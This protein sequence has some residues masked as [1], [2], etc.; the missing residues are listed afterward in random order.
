MATGLVWDERFMWHENDPTA[1]FL[2]PAGG[3]VQPGQHVEN[4]ETK[5][6]IKN[7]LDASGLTRDLVPIDAR[8]ATDE[9]ILSVHERGFLDSLKAQDASGGSAGPFSLFAAGGF[10]IIRLA[11]GGTLEALDAIMAGRIRNA[12]A[13]V[14]PCGHHATPDAGMGFA[15]LNNGAMAAERAMAQYGV[16]RVAIVD[17]DVHHGNGTQAI[18]WR[19]PRVLTISIHQEACF[20]P[21]GGWTDEVGEGPGEGYNINIALP[22][23]SGEGA[24]EAAMEEV[25]LPALRKFEPGLIIVPSGFDAGGFDP[26][27]RQML[28]SGAFRSMA[29]KVIDL[30]EAL[31]HGRVLAV[32]EGGYNSHTVPFMALAVIEELA[33][34]R[35]PV[36]D[37]FLPMLANAYGQAIR[38]HQQEAVDRARAVFERYSPHW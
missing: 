32:H 4:P 24:Y 35:S 29:R 1:A 2:M 6:R 20:P 5:R 21:E 28:S 33:G 38:P 31:G 34:V 3:Y 23:G 37:P 9:E 16:D 14:R 8:A 7:L 30:A 36:E 25:V 19:D 18:F 17:W 10:E 13:L 22:A 11:A 12:Y 15:F 27:A 26:L